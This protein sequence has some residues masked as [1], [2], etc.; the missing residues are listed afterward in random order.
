MSIL[1]LVFKSCVLVAS[2]CWKTSSM[3]D[4]IK[5][6]KS[7]LLLESKYEEIFLHISVDEAMW[8]IKLYEGIMLDYV[9]QNNN[10]TTS[11]N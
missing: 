8:A 5:I 9:K 7:E 4:L 2:S 10:N 6:D 11:Q 3:G 1:S